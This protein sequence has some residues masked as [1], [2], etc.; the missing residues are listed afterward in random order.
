MKNIDYSNI[1]VLVA[2]DFSSFRSTVNSMLKNLG[3]EDVEMAANPEEIIAWCED[4]FFDLILCDYSLGRGRNGQHVLEEL[5]Y[6]DILTHNTV[7]IMVSAEASRNIV[8]SAFDCKPDEYLMKPITAQML[9]QRMDRLM[10]MRNAFSKVY[11]RIDRN[12]PHEAMDLLI[13]MSL[14][15]NRHALLAQKQLGE[16]FMQMDMYDK[17]ERLYTKALDVRQLDWARL[18]LAKV[19]QAR[20]DLDLAGSWLQ[21]IIDENPLYL[22]AYDVLAENWEKKGDTHN[23]QFTVQKAVEISPMSIL[24]QRKLG[25]VARANKDLDTSIDALRNTV[26]L[27]MLSCHGSPENHFDFARIVSMGLEQK[28]DPAGNLGDEAIEILQNAQDWYQIDEG[29]KAQKLLITGRIHAVEGRHSEAEACLTDGA[30]TLQGIEG[31]V[32]AHLDHVAVLLGMDKKQEADDL[33]QSMKKIYADDQAVLEQLDEY[34]DEPASASNREMVAAV[35]REGIDLYNNA[36]HDA[37]LG[38]FER[39]RKLFP[40]HIGIQLNIVQTLIGKFRS[41]DKD[42]LIKNECYAALELVESLI[43]E[44]NPQYTRYKKLKNMAFSMQENL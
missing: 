33:L 15:E 4:R 28:K 13:D 7:F 8:M 11:E 22:P 1:S 40:K 43:D 32:Q 16:L 37:A 23:V 19:K 26:Q 39:A 10:S 38:C 17:A 20:G 21:T 36:R 34:L 42:S 2:D 31:S 44:S 5:R 24:R 9:Q 29:Q 30:E 3:V 12:E 41:G 35:N 14:A 25:D 18:G 6:R 27:G